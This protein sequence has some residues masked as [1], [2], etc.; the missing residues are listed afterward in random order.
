MVCLLA[1]ASR[2]SLKDWTE[3]IGDWITEL[4]FLD[5]LEKDEI[6]MLYSQL[7]YLCHAVPELWVTC[8]RACAALIASGA[9]MLEPEAVAS[10]KT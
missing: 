10:V 6:N 5:E 4:A 9:T 2:E 8:D 3:F 1:A 7:Q